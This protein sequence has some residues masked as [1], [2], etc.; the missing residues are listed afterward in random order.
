MGKKHISPNPLN[1]HTVLPH[2]TVKHNWLLSEFIVAK[3]ASYD[4]RSD[5]YGWIEYST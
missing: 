4:I 2:R 3:L 1:Y 5:W